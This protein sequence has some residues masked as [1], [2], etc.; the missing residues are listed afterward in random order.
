MKEV[1]F[2]KVVIEL[3]RIKIK[4]EKMKGMLDWLTSQE[5]KDIQKFLALTNYYW[6]FIKD[7]AF[8]AQLLYDLV[9]K[10]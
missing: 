5:V 3:D 8:I 7:F 10:D 2:F 4:K 6:W 9:K 1:R